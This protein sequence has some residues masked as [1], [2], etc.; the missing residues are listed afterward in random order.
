MPAVI[1]ST[2]T[3][4]KRSSWL[5]WGGDVEG[6]DN[7]LDRY[8]CSYAELL[9]EMGVGYMMKSG[10]S[11]AA[12]QETQK[13]FHRRIAEKLIRRCEVHEGGRV[14]APLESAVVSAEGQK[15]TNS[16][17]NWRRYF[18]LPPYIDMLREMGYRYT[19]NFDGTLREL[20]PLPRTE[21]RV[22]RLDEE[23]RTPAVC[24]RCVWRDKSTNFC[25]LVNCTRGR[26]S[27]GDRQRTAPLCCQTGCCR[28]CSQARPEAHH[29]EAGVRLMSGETAQMDLE[30]HFVPGEKVKP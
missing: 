17:Y 18:G 8:A 5:R 9:R 14:I 29:G 27:L 1:R 24:R 16:F 10:S 19:Y 3:A 23:V 12:Q 20:E 30:L 7:F 28:L 13:D 15:M 4:W 25:M 6:L 22:H 26:G 2:C 11:V 21:T